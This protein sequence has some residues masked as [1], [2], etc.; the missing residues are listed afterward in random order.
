MFPIGVI[1]NIGDLA[2]LTLGM[3]HTVQFIIIAVKKKKKEKKGKPI[4]RFI[5]HFNVFLIISSAFPKKEADDTYNDR[6]VLNYKLNANI[7][8]NGTHQVY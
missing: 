7:I 6:L 5:L 1:G 2:G 4:K 3:V 8:R